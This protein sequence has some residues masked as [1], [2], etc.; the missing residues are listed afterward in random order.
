MNEQEQAAKTRA[1]VKGVLGLLGRPA[2]RTQL[3]RLVYL[4]DSKFY[5]SLGRTITGGQYVWDACGPKSEGD[6]IADAADRLADDGE[7]RRARIQPGD[8]PEDSAACEYWADDPTEA[9]RSTDP[10]LNDGERQILMGI[11][12]KHG[13]SGDADLAAAAK[14][15][16]PFKNAAQPGARIKFVQS[17]RAIELHK[18]I[19]AQPDFIAEVM[20]GL[21]DEKAGRWVWDD[22]LEVR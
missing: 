10:A 19:A 6:A 17:A 1:A 2:S 9:W 13:H 4:A 15:T 18:M 8:D 16:P 3:V 22:E 5:E 7:I 14:Q 12:R 11:V 20:K 21:E